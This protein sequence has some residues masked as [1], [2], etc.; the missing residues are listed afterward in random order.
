MH[1]FISED[2][3][4]VYPQLR[5]DVR[6]TLL[7]SADN[8]LNSFDEKLAT[9]TIKHFQRQGIN[10]R[11]NQAVVKVDETQVFL[12]GGLTVPYGLLVWATGLGPTSFVSSLPFEKDEHSRLLVDEFCKVKGFDNMY[13]LGDA[14][15]ISRLNLP[16]SGKGKT[17][18]TVSL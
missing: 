16:A 6:I 11:T 10:V 7:E 9:Y 2:I 13:A 15:T 12:K 3:A 1:D 8:I 18:S 14:A 17:C 4:G 5:Y